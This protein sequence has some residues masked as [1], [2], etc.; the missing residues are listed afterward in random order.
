MLVV[1]AAFPQGRRDSSP[2]MR[3]FVESD[4]RG[5]LT[6]GTDQKAAGGMCF[7]RREGLEPPA[8]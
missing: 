5:A 8:F 3:N 7:A 4:A 1:I 2:A 6:N